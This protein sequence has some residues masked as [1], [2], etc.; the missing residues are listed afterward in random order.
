MPTVTEFSVQMEDR[1]GTLGKLCRALADRGVNIVAFQASPAE[2]GKNAVRLVTDNPTATKAVLTAEGTP[3][4]DMQVAQTTLP[5][6]PGSLANAAAKLGEAQIN[7]NYG[8][9]GVDPRTNA[10]IMIFGVADVARA[11]KILDE[12][13]AVAA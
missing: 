6:R 12:I 5:H 10:P 3:H 2:K 4:T 13:T 11:S 8:Y 7:I 9:A 1:P